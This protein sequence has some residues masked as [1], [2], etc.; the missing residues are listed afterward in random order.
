[1]HR[2]VAELAPIA[3]RRN[4]LGQLAQPERQQPAAEQP[5]Q[6]RDPVPAGQVDAGRR[7]RG[8]RGAEHRHQQ[9]GGPGRPLPGPLHRQGLRGGQA[10]GDRDRPAVVHV[11]GAQHRPAG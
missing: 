3:Q 1:M 9:G 5:G 11:A 8:Q 10:G 4:P 7:S 6:H 2:L